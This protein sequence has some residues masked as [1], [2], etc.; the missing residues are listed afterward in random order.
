MPIVAIT[1]ISRLSLASV[2][3]QAGLSLTWSD[4]PKGK[5]SHNEAQMWSSLTVKP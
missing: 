5:F 1:K 4:T 3:E 2:A